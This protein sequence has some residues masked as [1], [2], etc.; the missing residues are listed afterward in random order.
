MLRH[1]I[2]FRGMYVESS[3]SAIA[4]SK[5]LCGSSEEREVS[6][7]HARLIFKNNFIVK[8]I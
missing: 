3:M 6:N 1:G 2:Q 5:A 7:K 4:V 8:I